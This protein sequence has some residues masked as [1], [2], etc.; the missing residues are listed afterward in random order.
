VE[1]VKLELNLTQYENLM[2]DK[3]RVNCI[4]GTKMGFFRID[5]L[6]NS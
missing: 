6:R 3:F 1:N 4:S 5:Y 2:S